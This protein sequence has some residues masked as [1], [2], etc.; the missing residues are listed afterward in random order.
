MSATIKLLLAACLLLPASLLRAQLL[1]N[2]GFESGLDDWTVTEKTSISSSTAEAA[3]EGK[4]GLRINDESADSGANIASSRF[5]VTPGQ[6]ITL[7]FMARSPN[8]TIASV[9]ILPYGSSSQPLL[10]EKGRPPT[11][12]V[13]KQSSDWAHYAV[14]YVVPQ[15][16]SAFTISIRSWSTPT[17]IVDLDNFELKIE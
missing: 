1:T 4:A 8:G 14:E 17:G 13:I 2:P 16:A 9:S 15:E 5:D 3:Y 7:K 11:N 10:D 12:V 6:K